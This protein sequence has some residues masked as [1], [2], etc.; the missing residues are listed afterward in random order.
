MREA[1]K[2]LPAEVRERLLASYRAK[3]PVAPWPVPGPAQNR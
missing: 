3:R 2:P 1:V